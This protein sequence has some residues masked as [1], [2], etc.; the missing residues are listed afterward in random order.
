MI[1]ER[2]CPEDGSPLRREPVTYAGNPVFKADVCPECDGVWIDASE[3]DLV[4]TV[5]E[6]DPDEAASGKFA[7]GLLLGMI[8]G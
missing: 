7:K 3:L 8:Q 5:L 4:R 2:N 1:P 6:D